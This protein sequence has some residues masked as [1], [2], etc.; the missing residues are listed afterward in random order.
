M[1]RESGIGVAAEEEVEKPVARHVEDRAHLDLDVLG[2][3]LDLGPG[4]AG[5]V[6]I[7]ADARQVGHE[8]VGQVDQDQLPVVLFAPERQGLD[9]AVGVRGFHGVG[10]GRAGLRPEANVAADDQ[11]ALAGAVEGD[12]P[13]VAEVERLAAE[14]HQAGAAGDGD[15]QDDFLVVLVLPDLH[16]EFL[17]FFVVVEGEQAF[18]PLGPL[19]HFVPLGQL[20]LFLAGL[21][22]RFGR[23]FFRFHHRIVGQAAAQPG[24]IGE[25][26]TQQT[27]TQ[28]PQRVES[29]RSHRDISCGLR[30]KSV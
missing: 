19:D 5:G 28:E 4:A 12:D 22:R 3:H 25:N 29:V 9:D 16:E 13:L 15:G 30:R 1:P 10:L 24:T 11:Q 21:E 18:Q 20:L 17:L 26:G 2:K 6:G 8:K 27:Q 7:D 14:I 23:L